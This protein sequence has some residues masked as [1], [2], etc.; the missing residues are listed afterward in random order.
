MIVPKD[1]EN[2][3]TELDNFDI[4]MINNN[5]AEKGIKNFISQQLVYLDCSRIINGMRMMQTIGFTYKLELTKYLYA[6]DKVEDKNQISDYKDKLLALHVLNLAYE[7]DNPPIIY[8]KPIKEKSKSKP[9][10]RRKA[11][12]QTIPGFASTSPS[13][14]LASK[15]AG[16]V[17]VKFKL[18]LPK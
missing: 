4:N 12:E 17:N 14:T 10:R 11:K 2:Y 15:L 8:D 7:K 1:L 16:Y 18:K 13:K 6:L 3:V 9:A 5:I